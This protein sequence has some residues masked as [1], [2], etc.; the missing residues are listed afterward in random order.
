MVSEGNWKVIK[1]SEDTNVLQWADMCCLKD[2]Y[3]Q[4][5]HIRS[6]QDLEDKEEKKNR[7]KM[8]CSVEETDTLDILYCYVM[9]LQRL[10]LNLLLLSA[11]VANK[12]AGFYVT[13]FEQ[14]IIK[15]C[16]LYCFLIVHKNNCIHL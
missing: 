12:A 1:D 13:N 7:G 16:S 2:S 3:K 6:I 9:Y 10:A 5:T 4:F 15:P 14:N 11:Y 8:E